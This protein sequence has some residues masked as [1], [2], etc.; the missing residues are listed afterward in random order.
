[1]PSDKVP[2]QPCFCIKMDWGNEE[3][4]GPFHWE[5]VRE[6]FALLSTQ[7]LYT[8]MKNIRN[9]ALTVISVYVFAMLGL[10]TR[11]VFKLSFA[12]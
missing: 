7:L 6:F 10:Q 9:I 4:H 12:C 3:M 5:D 2:F 1:M 11:S 8:T